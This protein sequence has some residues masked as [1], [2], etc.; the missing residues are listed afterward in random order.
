MRLGIFNGP[1]SLEAVEGVCDGGPV[2]VVDSLTRLVEQS[3][4][5]RIANT[6]HEPRYVLLELVRERARELLGDELDTLAER[7]AT[8]VVDFLE[9][10]D[11]RRWAA[12]ADRWLDDIT[13]VQAEVRAAHSWAVSSGRAELAA[14]ITASLGTYWHLD[15]HHVEGRQWVEQALASAVE[16]DEA[17]RAG[18]HLAGGFV[19]WPID[20]ELARGHWELAVEKYRAVGDR[21]ML[22]YA[23]PKAAIG[24]LGDPDRYDLA[25]KLCDEGIAL[26]RE[27]GDRPLIAPA[28]NVR[29]ELTRIAGHDD[30]ARAAYEEGRDLSI[31]AGDDAHLSVFLANLS[32]ISEHEGDY[33]ESGRL[34]RESLRLAWSQGRRLM[35]AW[36]VDKLA[37]PE[38]WLGRP[39][40]AVLLLGASDQ[41]L[42]LLGVGLH[43]GDQPE[44]D[45][46]VAALRESLGPQR[47]DQLHR[48]GA[49]MS[50]DEAVALALLDPDEQS[51]EATGT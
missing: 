22:A 36:T 38:L 44:H 16:L 4:V 19:M 6:R 26:S 33:E 48:E 12:A 20:Q 23:L 13:D 9:D 21:R 24:F 46:V 2:D 3:L 28:L 51:A 25:I 7:H 41:A 10:L 8:Y 17:T 31:A 34:A 43:P 49:A 37:G 50:L 40:R 5:R 47:Y 45:R 42:G 14:R 1:V 29:G 35:S 11:V 18:I 30:E 32:Y 27:I 15:G 39:E